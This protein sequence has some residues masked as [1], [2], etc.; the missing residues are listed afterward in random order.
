MTKL[1]SVVLSLLPI[2]HFTIHEDS[3]LPTLKPGDSVLVFKWLKIKPG[4]VVVA[5]QQDRV[6]IK[7]IAK[8]IGKDYYLLGDNPTSS[9][10]SRKLGPVAK[11]DILGAV[12]HISSH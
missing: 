10:D 11:R 1:I 4:D 6:V 9:L 12:V 7:K 5:R 8:I 2:L 3:M